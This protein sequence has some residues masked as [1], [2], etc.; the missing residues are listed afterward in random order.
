MA[1]TENLIKF[2]GR[3][4]HLITPRNAGDLEED[5]ERWIFIIDLLDESGVTYDR[6]DPDYIDSM[7]DRLAELLEPAMMMADW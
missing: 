2:E 7:E 4:Q 3:T 5:S 1:T 6:H